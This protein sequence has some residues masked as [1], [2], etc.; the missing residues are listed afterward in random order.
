MRR[1]TGH[2]FPLVCRITDADIHFKARAARGASLCGAFY[3]NQLRCFYA[4]RRSHFAVLHPAVASARHCFR[5]A[6]PRNQENRPE[7]QSLYRLDSRGPFVIQFEFLAG[8]HI[9]LDLLA[10]Q[11]TEDDHQAVGVAACSARPCTCCNAWP[12]ARPNRRAPV[13][14]GSKEGEEMREG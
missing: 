5:P 3:K 13:R 12:A 10:L 4:C 1:R 9:V 2:D 8:R 11:K 6:P 7:P 14:S